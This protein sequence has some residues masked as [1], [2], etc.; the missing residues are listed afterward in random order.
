MSTYNSKFRDA[1]NRIET[2]TN[3]ARGSKDPKSARVYTDLAKAWARVAQAI[4][5]KEG[6]G[7]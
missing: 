1:L 2:Y 3:K 6:N 5:V 4:A 7:D